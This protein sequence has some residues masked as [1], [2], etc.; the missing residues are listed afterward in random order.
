MKANAGPALPAICPRS[1]RWKPRSSDNMKILIPSPLLSY[2]HAREVLASGSTVMAVLADLDRQFPGLRH[3]MVDEQD[4]IR[5]HM[6]VFV[7]G[8]QTFDLQQQVHASDIV[9]IIQAL[10]GG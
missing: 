1:T 4:H 9:Q 7:N 5:P 2:T 3:R 10:S 8:E 6:R